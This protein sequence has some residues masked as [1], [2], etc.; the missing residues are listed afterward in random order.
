LIL[1]VHG[2]R[3]PRWREPFERLAAGL[4]G[5]LGAAAVRLAYLELIPPTL[6]EV[7]AE[8][9]RDGVGRLRL[10][11]LFMAGGTHVDRDIPAQAAAVRERFPNLAVEVLPSIG[12]DARFIRLL[13]DLASEAARG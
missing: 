6:M 1:L 11:P 4:A 7:A 9:A 12:D 8:A 3:D 2:S 13:R 10:L 5:D